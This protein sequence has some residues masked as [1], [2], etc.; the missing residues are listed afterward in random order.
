MSNQSLHELFGGLPD[1]EPEAPEP[2]REPRSPRQRPAALIPWIVVGAVTVVALI[3]S[4]MIVTVARGSDE[5]EPDPAPAPTVQAS[6]DPTPEPTPAPE[7]D[8]DA[9][10]S[11]PDVQVGPTF[12]MPI[13][14]WGVTADVS[15]K[16]GAVTYRFEDGDSTLLLSSPLIESLPQS[17]EAMKSQWGVRRSGSGYELVK[18]S[19]RCDEAG[20]VYDEIWGLMDALVDSI[21]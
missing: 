2:Q 8:E 11:V 4:V 7:P 14:A 20:A 16:L 6:A 3:A 18:P 12:D 17:C 15:N 13:D 1:E 10:D 5:A 21:N 9:E 19:E